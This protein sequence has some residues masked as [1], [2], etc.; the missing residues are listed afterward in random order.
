MYNNKLDRERE[1]GETVQNINVLAKYHFTAI[2][3]PLEC[4]LAVN[5]TTQVWVLCILR[6]ATCGELCNSTDKGSSYSTFTTAVQLP[7]W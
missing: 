4:R 6:F 3:Q 7:I 1:R 2:L 5:S